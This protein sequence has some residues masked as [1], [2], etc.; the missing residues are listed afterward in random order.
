MKKFVT[1]AIVTLVFS[2]SYAQDH[3][4]LIQRPVL[5]S[6]DS[7]EKVAKGEK[8]DA[9]FMI[10]VS[11]NYF[12]NADKFN[13]A[14]PL[15]FFRKDNPFQLEMN[16]YYSVPDNVIRLV[17]YSWDCNSKQTDD[18]NSLFEKNAKYFTGYFGKSG[19]IKNEM[20]DAWS[21]KSIT[22]QNDLVHIYQF[23]VTGQGTNRVRVL[24]SWK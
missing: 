21:Q 12:P 15:I 24:I 18:L 6:V 14:N 9:P 7:I 16:Y 2:F 4:F 13:L 8:F 23:M 22:W 5:S 20:H 10:S 19:E 1:S 3:D 11:K 17:S